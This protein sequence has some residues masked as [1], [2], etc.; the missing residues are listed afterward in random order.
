VIVATS[1]SPEFG[2]DAS[3]LEQLQPLLVR[4]L[5]LPL[6]APVCVTELEVCLTYQSEEG[7]LVQYGIHPQSLG[8]YPKVAQVTVF[9]GIFNG[10][11]Y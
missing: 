11:E 8:V 4:L 10:Y 7:D 3:W 6:I 2:K 5:D 9:A 1:P